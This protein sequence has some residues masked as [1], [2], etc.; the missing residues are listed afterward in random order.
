MPGRRFFGEGAGRAHA[1]RAAQNKAFLA[2]RKAGDAA[3]GRDNA[4]AVAAENV[5]Q[6]RLG[7][8]LALARYLS[9]GFRPA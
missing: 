7:R 9:A 4:D 6:R 8:I 2:G 1:D 5:R 3:D